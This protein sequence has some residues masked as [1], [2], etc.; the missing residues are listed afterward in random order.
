MNETRNIDDLKGSGNVVQNVLQNVA[1]KVIS[2]VGSKYFLWGI[3]AWF[4]F[5]GIYMI[6]N[7]NFGISPDEH[8][9]YGYIQ[10]FADNGFSP[11]FGKQEKYFKLG[12][13][14]HNPYFLYHYFMSI[15]YHLF[16]G[17]SDS[18]RILRLLNLPL[19]CGSLYV[20]YLLGRELGIKPLAVNVAI[21]VTSNTLMFVFL[22]SSI[23]Y[24]NLMILLSLLAILFLLRLWKN[25]HI[26]TYLLF[27]ITLLAGS[28]TKMSFLPI[29]VASVVL[30]IFRYWRTP[31]I[32]VTCF[33]TKK[34]S[35]L[36]MVLLALCV[37]LA[38]SV[39]QIYV[40]NLVEYRA[41]QPACDQV[42]SVSNCM[43]NVIYEREVDL[44][45][46]ENPVITL[47]TLEYL[48]KWSTHMSNRAFGIL[49][50]KS[51][52]P[53]SLAY[54]A[55]IVVLLVG[56]AGFARKVKKSDT[57]IFVAL[58]V[59]GAYLLALIREN[60]STYL[61]TGNEGLAVQGRY[62]FPVY[63][64]LL[65]LIFHYSF[66]LLKNLPLKASYIMLICI[67]FWF[68]SFPNFVHK[69]SPYEAWHNAFRAVDVKVS[70]TNIYSN[71]INADFFH[72]RF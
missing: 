40:N 49:G 55:A 50:H 69:T 22:S 68:L 5:Q 46:I 43:N 39:T 36:T 2:I 29:L 38:V 16:Q 52:P 62:M 66:K 47:N 13:I 51:I 7:T 64:I 34:W 3:F 14:Q 24:D 20:T 71:E 10:A 18:F 30:L 65:L 35:K 67:I 37:L 23:N 17:Q 1:R 33:F 6:F 54:P 12:Q 27:L 63:S 26:K 21:F 60:H 42:L 25:F 59:S 19:G 48:A 72:S 15:P 8:Y 57:T 56:L 53:M 45:K 58:F 9:H 32:L 11:F 44:D 4:V 70:N 41:I 31:W 61:E 28:L